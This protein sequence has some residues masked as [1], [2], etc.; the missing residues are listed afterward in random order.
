MTTIDRVL[1][2]PVV[3]KSPMLRS[4]FTGMWLGWQI[5]TNWADPLI[6][7]TYFIVRPVAALIILVVMY[8]IIAQDIIGTPFFAYVYLGSA[9]YLLA[10][11]IVVGVS[12]VV[13]EDREQYRVAKQIHTAP[14]SGYAY[15]LGRG[16]ARFAVSVLS[17][18]ITIPF[19]VLAFGLPVTWASIQVPLL[20]VSTLL[21]LTA[22]AALG[23]M[24][25]AYTLQ[26]TRQVFS[27]GDAL[28]G[29]LYLLTGAVFPIDLL[30]EFLRP[31]S[32][33]LPTTYWLEL[34]RRA[35]VAEP[36]AFQSVSA[37]S[38]EALLAILAAMAAAFVIASGFVFRWSMRIAKERGV[39]DME[40]N[41]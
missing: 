8:S 12:W 36:V 19:G 10:N 39:L 11:Q 6:F 4:L 28:S 17:V 1:S 22:M 24:I 41:Y 32:Y 3:R 25:G 34:A 40:T 33:A 15:L 9:L 31:L 5:E 27:V 26:I 14:I 23:V 37:L 29:A 7:L 30:P 18:S 13:I 21:G 16:L 2:S 38:T 20:L 35:L